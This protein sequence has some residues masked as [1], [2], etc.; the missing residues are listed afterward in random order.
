MPG[1]GHA[2]QI[3]KEWQAVVQ[4]KADE[5]G[6][7]EL[8]RR[9]GIAASSLVA[10]LK[11]GAIQTT[12]MAKINKAVGLPPPLDKPSPVAQE[13][14]RLAG[15]LEPFEQGRWLEKLVRAVEESRRG[16]PHK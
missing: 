8:A 6:L 4:A 3:T 16:K 9:A 5:V 1:K 11:D 14:A 2:Y 15:Q 10:A 12:K 7:R 13:I